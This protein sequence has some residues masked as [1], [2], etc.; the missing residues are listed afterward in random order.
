MPADSAR[1]LRRQLRELGLSNQAIDAAWP[2]WWSDEAEGSASA[3]AELWF[4]V[5]RRL[6]LDPRSMLDE[7][8]PRFRGLERARFK[9]LSGEDDVERAG[10]TSYGRA[11][12]VLLLAGVSSDVA[13]I[14][15][16]SALD[17]RQALLGS[18][19]PYV[20]L[21][22]LLAFAWGVGIPVVHLR[23]FPWKQKRMA[24]MTVSVD[25]RPA[26]LLGKDS[27]YPAAIAFYLAHE[28]AHIA[29]GHLVRD[30]LIVDLEE[31]SLTAGGDDEER[32]ADTYAL[33]VLTGR[34]QLQVVASAAGA[35]ATARGLAQSA[36]QV[37]ASLRIEPG[38]IA[39]LFGYST[40][41]WEKTNAALRHIYAKAL[42]VWAE[43]NGYARTQ[44]D[45]EA[46]PTD[47]VDFL[48]ALLGE[49][50]Q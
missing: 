13:D 37:A 48:N 49:P 42:P 30:D 6:G 4:S 44:L 15:G 10:I 31:A 22:D 18:E 28:I 1:Q 41:E 46:I 39:Q 16:L 8:A 11:V 2:A 3:R 29:L 7:G 43:V 50:R 19:R 14:T 47:A 34:P 24:A 5:A 36:L 40:G 35:P 26:I 17:L 33:E 9:H 32:T 25:K 23:I 45:L 21:R 38:V 27:S 12:A 20:E